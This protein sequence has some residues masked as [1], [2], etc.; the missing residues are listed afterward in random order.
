M[1]YRF[2]GA[3]IGEQEC[4]TCNRNP[5]GSTR[6]FVF[7]C[8][9]HGSCT[10]VKPLWP[11]VDGR[12]RVCNQ[13]P[14]RDACVSDLAAGGKA[15]W[16]LAN[17][18]ALRNGRHIERLDCCP[19]PDEFFRRWWETCTPVVFRTAVPDW[20]FDD[21]A[22]RFGDREVEIQAGRSDDPLYERRKHEHKAK[23]QFGDF[24]RRVTTEIT[25]DV[26]M[27]AS[28][29]GHNRAALAELLAEAPSIPALI[30][31]QKNEFLWIS[32][33]GAITPTHHDLDCILLVQVRGQKRVVM[34]AP[35]WSP[36]MQNRQHVFS[37]LDLTA[38]QLPDGLQPQEVIIGAGDAL[39][40]PVGWW[41]HVT[42]LE[43]SIMLSYTTFVGHKSEFYKN[44]PR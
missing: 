24:I 13:C 31:D 22:L 11:E 23:V 18:R 25:N 32:P 8:R 27:T 38:G 10:D 30:E 16:L 40:L 6:V 34:A 44:F 14:D 1:T 21:I 15:C 17:M 28:E 9:L 7:S 20:T 39:F 4:P 43:P 42:T 29:T 33:A 41:H 19:E 5:G 35:E 3:K 36:L 12:Y 2:R 26:Y 37:D